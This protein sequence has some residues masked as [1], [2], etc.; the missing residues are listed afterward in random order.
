MKE[1]NW[2]GVANHPGPESWVVTSNGDGQALTGGGAGR[3]SSREIHAPWPAAWDFW[4][5]D[6]LR[7]RGRPHPLRRFR[8]ATRD[9][10]RSE[11]PYTYRHTAHGNREIPRPTARRGAVRIGKSKDKRR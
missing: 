5:A 1:S 2:K 6:A 9:P 4:G 10:T 8:E 7:I 3:P 11:T